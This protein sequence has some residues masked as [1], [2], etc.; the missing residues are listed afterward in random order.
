MVLTARE[1][2]LASRLMVK[3][4]LSIYGKTDTNTINRLKEMYQK[5]HVN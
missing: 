4:Y 3:P 1:L 2:L 5:H